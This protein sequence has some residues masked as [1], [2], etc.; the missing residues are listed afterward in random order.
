MRCKNTILAAS[1]IVL[2][3]ISGVIIKCRVEAQVKELFKMNK[4]CQE[5]SYYMAEFEFKLLGIAYYIDKG[6]YYTAWT[7]LNQLH[8]Q[9]KTKEELI[10]V[11]EFTSKEDEMEFYLNLQNPKTGAF[12]DDSYPYCTYNEPTENVVLHLDALAREIG[13]PL[14]LK[15][16]LKYLDKINKPERL[17]V[18]LD[19]VSHVGWIVAKFP[20]T[21]YVFAR[22]LLSYANEEGVIGKNH[23]YN[24][25]PYLKHAM[26]QWFYENQDPETG[27]W[28]PRSKWSGNLLIKDLTNTASIIKGFVDANGTDI[29]PS[30]PLRYKHKMF[31][32]TLQIMSEPMPDDDALDEWHDWALRMGKGTMM[33]TRYLWKDASQ[34]DKV[35]AKKT[36]ESFIRTSFEKYYIPND[37]SFSY[38]PNSQHATMDGTGKINEFDS[39]GFFSGEQQRRLWGNPQKSMTDLGSHEISE[40][41]EQDFALIKNSVGINSLRFYKDDLDYDNLTDNVFA[42]V[43]AQKTSVLDVMDVTPK[44]KLWMS[45]TS[46]SMGNWTSR[47]EILQKLEG[48]KIEEVP[49]YTKNIPLEN[50]NELLKTNST[51]VVIGFDVL[52]IPRYKI[53]FELKKCNRLPGCP[54]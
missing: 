26:L 20:Q 16:P 54:K 4:E 31:K 48:L 24:Y 38:Y 11:P 33:L 45:T 5:E 41:S 17:T 50:A 3:A 13:R 18:F 40:F 37:G 32:T 46:Q 6:Y 7:R 39:M 23:L 28:G 22:S 43:Y 53:T 10:K 34:E 8:K 42:V 9:L 27:F 15:Y 52:Q 12:M 44:M 47:E 14:H 1:I 51:L 35:Q 2:L 29:H 19:D 30:F 49:V 25:S 21:S 36:F